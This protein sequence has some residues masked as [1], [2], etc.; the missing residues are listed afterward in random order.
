MVTNDAFIVEFKHKV[1]TEICRLAWDDNMT[2]DAKNDN[3]PTSKD[4]ESI[5]D[6]QQ[7][8]SLDSKLNEQVIG[9]TESDA[10][11]EPLPDDYWED[12]EF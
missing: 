3:R 8:Q 12:G 1:I 6:G 9:N 7:A 11:S 10:G 4:C 2:E 5:D